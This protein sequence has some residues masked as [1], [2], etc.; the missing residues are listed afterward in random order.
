MA[1][2]Y[3]HAQLLLRG[4]LAGNVVSSITIAIWIMSCDFVH[5]CR[6]MLRQKVCAAEEERTLDIVLHLT[7]I[8]ERPVAMKTDQKASWDSG[9]VD[10]TQMYMALRNVVTCK[11]EQGNQSAVLAVG[12]LHAAES[13]DTGQ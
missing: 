11:S 8:L 13:A 2:A 1:G 7:L 10:S 5:Y 6:N 3:L 9:G 12:Y 4:R